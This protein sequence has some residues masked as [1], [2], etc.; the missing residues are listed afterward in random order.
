MSCMIDAIEGHD[1]E[2]A[3]T[4]GAF[5]QTDYNKVDINIK[6]GG[7]MVTLLEDIDTSYYK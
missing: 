3:D 5:L 1:V 7:S 2:T 6:I 4:P